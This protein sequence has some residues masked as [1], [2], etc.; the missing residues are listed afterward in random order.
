MAAE[1]GGG[2]KSSEKL[3]RREK[4]GI[5][6]VVIALFPVLA[7]V[8]FMFVVWPWLTVINWVLG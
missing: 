7:M 4:L 5:A 3:S 6:A 2:M 1:T 8:L